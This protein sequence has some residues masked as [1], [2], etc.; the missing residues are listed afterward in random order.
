MTQSQMEKDLD[1]LHCIVKRLDGLLSNR[2]IGAFTWL[3]F[4]TDNMGDLKKWVKKVMP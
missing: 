3:T 2:Q 4:L 1:D